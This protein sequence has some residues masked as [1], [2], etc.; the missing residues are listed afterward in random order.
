M[1]KINQKKLNTNQAVNKAWRR[2]EERTRM[3]IFKWKLDLFQGPNKKRDKA[4]IPKN[5]N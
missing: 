1:Y 4:G 5:L 3:Q 2:G